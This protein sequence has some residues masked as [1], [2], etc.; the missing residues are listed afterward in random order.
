MGGGKSGGGTSSSTTS[1]APPAWLQKELQNLGSQAQAMAMKPLQQ[2]SG[3]TVAGFTPDQKQAMSI[4]SNA[5]GMAQP[6][7]NSAAQYF[8]NATTPLAPTIQPYVDQSGQTLQKGM[9]QL[10]PNN[11]ASRMSPYIQNVVDATQAQFN[12]A[13][14]QQ[15]QQL[16]GNAISSGAWGGDRASVAQGILGGQQQLSQAPQIANLY[17]QGWQ[18]AGQLATAAGQQD[19]AAAQQQLAGGNAVLGANQANAWLNSQVGAGMMGLGTTAENEALQ[20]AQSL[21]SVGNQQQTLAQN[22]LN[23]PYEQFLQQQAYPY[24]QASWLSGIENGLGSVVGGNSTTT[25]LAP[26]ASTGSQIFGGLTAGAG[27]LGSLFGGGQ[28][29]AWNGMFGNRG[30][31]M[32]SQ[33][34]ALGGAA[35]NNPGGVSGSMA[36]GQIMHNIGHPGYTTTTT[37]DGG[38]GGS[39]LLPVMLAARVAAAAYSGGTSEAAVGAPTSLVAPATQFAGGFNPMTSAGGLYAKGG[40]IPALASGGASDFVSMADNGKGSPAV[41]QFDQALF[42]N[43]SNTIANSSGGASGMGDMMNALPRQ[44]VPKGINTGIVMPTAEQSNALLGIMG[45]KGPDKYGNIPDLTYGVVSKNN[46][47]GLNQ[48][49]YATWLDAPNTTPVSQ[50]LSNQGKVADT[51]FNPQTGNYQAVKTPTAVAPKNYTDPTWDELK[52]SWTNNAPTTTKAP[53]SYTAT[54][55]PKLTTLPFSGSQETSA[56]KGQQFEYEPTLLQLSAKGGI[57]P[58]KLADGDIVKPIPEGIVPREGKDVATLTDNGRLTPPPSRDITTSPVDPYTKLPPL[59]PGHGHIP[60][61]NQNDASRA[62]ADTGFTEGVDTTDDS[63]VTPSY[64]GVMPSDI[65]K[66]FDASAL[67]LPPM[68]DA[69]SPDFEKYAEAMQNP[70]ADPW[71]SLMTAGLAMMAGKSPNAWANI[72]E[73]ALAGIANYNSQKE[74][75]AKRAGEVFNAETRADQ[76]YNAGMQAHQKEASSRAKMVSDATHQAMQEANQAQSI[77]LRGSGMNNSYIQRYLFHARQLK[78]DPNQLTPEQ[79]HLIRQMVASE[80]NKVQGDRASIAGPGIPPSLADQQKIVQGGTTP[81]ANVPAAPATPAAPANSAEPSTPKTPVETP[82]QTPST[83][84]DWSAGGRNNWVAE[85]AEN[86]P[87]Q[88]SPF[89]K[90]QMEGLAAKSLDKFIEAGKSMARSDASIQVMANALNTMHTDATGEARA[91]AAAL[92]NAFIGPD[93]ATAVTGMDVDSPAVFEKAKLYSSLYFDRETMGS[94]PANASLKMGLAAFPSLNNTNTANKIITQ[95]LA[96]PFQRHQDEQA[97]IHQYAQ[98]HKTNVGATELFERL[99]PLMEYQSRIMPTMPSLTGGYKPG[100]TYF[101]MEQK[102]PNGEPIAGTW[103]KTAKG[104]GFLRNSLHIYKP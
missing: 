95:L 35:V 74:A 71:M 60:S 46:P 103:V 5:Q 17:N 73:G 77:Q 50:W 76:L 45:G 9:S 7:Y 15:N 16:V 68:G 94:R 8:Q 31:V 3:E 48:S 20:G 33:K 27:A 37:S 21:M 101:D 51:I 13:N 10:D 67:G 56:P 40:I 25:S 63:G 36:P 64:Q 6:Y 1:N 12:N 85:I 82:A 22:Q 99:H 11:I 81:G 28:N 19:I 75:N 92:L 52:G 83:R 2:Y 80:T 24:Q 23:V 61:M 30:G 43:M 72:G 102:G 84:T 29:S 55:Q 87:I 44:E 53:I 79:D 88:Y 93:V 97:F 90:H 59:P 91:A 39:W 54:P 26:Q 86:A 89:E 65:A 42:H 98:T 66:R 70:K 96:I 41:P 104:E 4:V 78:L 32:R 62:A 100:Y 69:R 34:L 47:F 49:D 57:I 18:N 38:D 14:Q 58:Q